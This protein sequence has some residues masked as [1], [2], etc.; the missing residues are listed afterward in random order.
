MH[1]DAYKFYKWWDKVFNITNSILNGSLG[2]YSV[3][4]LFLEEGWDIPLAIIT[5]I[6][7]FITILTS[8]FNEFP[9]KAE[10]Q[11]QSSEWYNTIYLNISAQL[12]LPR[13]KRGDARLFIL[14]VKK[15]FDKYHEEKAC[16]PRFIYNKYID[17]SLESYTITQP[18]QVSVV[19]VV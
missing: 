10:R 6:V 1:K 16:I 11:L 14:N 2:T 18:Q 8:N 19:T 7:T 15:E 5:I 9:V 4:W 3:V 17:Q 13:S 12:S